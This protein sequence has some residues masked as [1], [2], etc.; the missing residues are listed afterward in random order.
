MKKTIIIL[1]VILL[2]FFTACNVN[3]DVKTTEKDVVYETVEY[4]LYYVP[5]AG[6]TAIIDSSPKISSVNVNDK[7]FS[8]R[9][10][11][12]NVS[13][14][15][16][17]IK[18]AEVVIDGKSH[19]VNYIG[20]YADEVL[21]ND[22]FNILSAY[23]EYEGETCNFQIRQSDNRLLFFFNRNME[24]YLQEGDLTEEQAKEIA[25]EQLTLLY[26]ST[27]LSEYQQTNVIRTDD[28]LKNSYTVV[29]TKYVYGLQTEDDISITLNMQGEIIGINASH[30]GVFNNAENEL[31]K[32]HIDNAV[33]ALNDNFS[34]E[35]TIVGHRLVT[36][37][38]GDYY[39]RANGFLTSE[40]GNEA[41]VI[42]VNVK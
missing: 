11:E 17:K 20:S 23:D 4:S 5:S 21:L 38:K 28:Q 24:K 7:N 32:E 35:W 2:T 16:I 22:K 25:K 40:N 1:I 27:V 42:Y 31:S 34:K 41:I 6:G 8:G 18:N 15:K 14:E 30:L 39:I 33:S 19:N 12:L 29:Y 37:S 9:R 36:D 3:D 10:K 26:G 13:S